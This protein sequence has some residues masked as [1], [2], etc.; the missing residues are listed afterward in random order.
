MSAAKLPLVFVPHG[1]GPWPFV[2]LGFPITETQAMAS[3]LGGL[4]NVAV[5]S[6]TSVLMISAHWEQ[7]VPTVSTALAP[8]MLYDY[9]G[10]PAQ[11]YQVKWPAP[12]SPT[13]A[14][15]VRDLL[16][17]A[18][19]DTAQDSTRGFDHGTFVP[20]KL[21]YPNADI[22]TVQLSLKSGLDADEHLAIGLA[23]APL[24]EQGVFIIGSGMTFH[25][26]NAFRSPVPALPH[27]EA[28]DNWLVETCQLD[29]AARNARL[30]HW[31]SAPS[32][33]FCHPR[34][35]HL[36]PLMVIAGAA[37]SDIGTVPFR[38]CM[39]GLPLSGYQFG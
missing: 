28:F 2:G 4:A 31:T 24:R 23:L 15:T 3:Y 35:E 17:N 30:R 10:F 20:M 38:G 26:M 37:G 8:P 9:S 33:R 5:P 11:A 19:I 21:A 14:A 27:A 6:P 1:G 32:A 25:N 29:S 22:P 13:L 36:L 7:R 12:G 16:A 39:F 34:E 18:G